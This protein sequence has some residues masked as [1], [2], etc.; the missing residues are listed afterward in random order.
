[1]LQGH[2]RP[3]AGTLRSIKS[4]IVNVLHKRVSREEQ[5]IPG[6]PA[7][8]PHPQNAKRW[9]GTFFAQ[10]RPAT[11]RNRLDD[12]LPESVLIPVGAIPDL[13]YGLTDDRENVWGYT[14]FRQWD[15]QQTL[16]DYR[17]TAVLNLATSGR[18]RG[19]RNAGTA[20]GLLV[21]IAVLHHGG[22]G[23]G[24]RTLA[25]EDDLERA[26]V[27]NRFRVGHGMRSCIT[28]RLTI[29]AGCSTVRFGYTD[30]SS[31][32]LALLIPAFSK[33]VRSSNVLKSVA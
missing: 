17:P 30:T 13:S 8:P 11:G 26:K 23:Y 10:G 6:S 3:A 19:A 20:V 16:Y 22:A 32:R 2:V 15:V 28:D 14:A 4:R 31:A 7:L 24:L 27:T 33:Q 5:P 9:M 18:Q 1:M 25:W 21:R 29:S 12:V